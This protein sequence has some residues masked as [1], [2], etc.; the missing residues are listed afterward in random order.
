ML[1]SCQRCH[2]VLL[3]PR[4]GAGD[5]AVKH[6][7]LQQRAC[8]QCCLFSTVLLFPCYLVLTSMQLSFVPVCSLLRAALF[9]EHPLASC[10]FRA[11]RKQPSL[12]NGTSRFCCIP[13]YLTQGP[14]KC[15]N[16]KLPW[17]LLITVQQLFLLAPGKQLDVPK[18]A[19]AQGRGGLL[20][21]T[22]GVPVLYR[23]V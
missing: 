21:I 16:V 12:P 3:G 7:R 18:L 8:H 5:L 9:G 4:T 22:L 20:S 14:S 1:C 10:L 13:I 11:W 2:V 23:G 15:R 19:P 17:S 6:W